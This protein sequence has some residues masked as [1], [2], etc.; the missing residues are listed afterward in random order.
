MGFRKRWAPANVRAGWLRAAYLVAFARFG[1]RYILRPELDIVRGQI[2]DPTVEH[3]PRAVLHNYSHAPTRRGIWIVERPRPLASVH[4]AIGRWAMFLPGLGIDSSFY[5][6][7]AAR[8]QWPPR[9]TLRG[10]SATWP[11][12]PVLAF[13]WIEPDH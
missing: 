3:A 1:Y 7:L 10:L 12:E 5:E 2:A 13:D 11:T 6:N 8:K 4:V 9:G